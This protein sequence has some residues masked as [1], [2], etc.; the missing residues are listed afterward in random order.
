MCLQDD[1]VISIDVLTEYIKKLIDNGERN[2]K[3][4]K[5]FMKV[6]G[7]YFKIEIFANPYVKRANSYL[8]FHKNCFKF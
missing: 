1:D 5:M 3:R 8:T 7:R 6:Y 2:S 4:F